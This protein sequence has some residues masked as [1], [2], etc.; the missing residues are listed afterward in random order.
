MKRL[1]LILATFVAVL[2]AFTGSKALAYDITI[3]GDTT[4]HTYESYQI[5]TGDLND[6][7]L[8]NIQWGNGITTDGQTALQNKY[9]VSSASA[10]AEKM[11]TFSASQTEEFA[12]LAG[13]YLQNPGALTG[14]SAGYYL[15]KDKDGS[16]KGAE[17]AAYTSYILQVVKNVTVTPKSGTPT[18]EKKVKDTNDTTGET[19]DWQDSADYDINDDVPF[20]LTATLPAENFDKYETYYLEFSDTMSKGLTFNNN[21]V[22]KVGDKT[23]TADQYQLTTTTDTDGSTKLTIAINDVKALGGVAGGKVTVDYSAKLNENAVIG[24]KGNP[25]EVALIYSNNPNEKGTGKPNDTGKTPKD[26]V[27]VFTYKTVVNKVDKDKQPLK[28]A[29]FTLYKMVKGTKTKVKEITAGEATKFEFKGLDDGDYVLEETTTPAG[30]NTIKPITFTVEAKHDTE[31]AE[32][33]LT[34]LTGTAANGEITFT[35]AEANEDALTTQVV[36]KKGSILPSTGSV[37]TTILYIAGA[38]LVLGAGILLITK[39]RMEA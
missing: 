9:S 30:Y 2:F 24:S 4:G 8:S 3:N 18:V 20:Q 33:K 13:K 16:L 27:I 7:T 28:G 29:G 32:P 23:L 12:S 1:K 38:I 36:N 37:G 10:L 26:T 31:A 35:R 5:F 6:N 14:L 17:K 34:K 22:V 39:K 15:V 21:A 19:T 25:N 11:A